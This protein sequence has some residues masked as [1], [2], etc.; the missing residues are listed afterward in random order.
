MVVAVLYVFFV[1]SLSKGKSHLQITV[2]FKWEM[3][4]K[5]LNNYNKLLENINGQKTKQMQRFFLCVFHWGSKGNEPKSTTRQT[6]YLGSV[7][8]ICVKYFF[9]CS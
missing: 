1:F 7:L 6:K 5:K 9:S 2:A 8:W 3:K 4:I